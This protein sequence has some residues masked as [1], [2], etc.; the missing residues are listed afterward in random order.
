MKAPVSFQ[1]ASP[2]VAI[3]AALFC[4]HCGGSVSSGSGGTGGNNTGGT[5]G[6][7][8]GGTGGA[9]GST[10]TGGNT[11]TGGAAGFPGSGGIGG[12]TGSP[13]TFACGAPGTDLNCKVGVELCREQDS[14]GPITYACV[15][16]QAS[17]QSG[18]VCK[19]K[20]LAPGCGLG[21]TPGSFSCNTDPNGNVFVGCFG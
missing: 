6:N 7:S 13:G 17:C 2:V 9:A 15:P 14:A 19:C 18:D 16:I 5:G 11:G 20:D 12:G 8:T 1:K 4:I 10:S 3:F 21:D